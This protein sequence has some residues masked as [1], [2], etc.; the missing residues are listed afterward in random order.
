M[1]HDHSPQTDK[2]SPRAVS[3][4]RIFLVRKGESLPTNYRVVAENS[5]TL[6]CFH[7]RLVEAVKNIKI[8]V[9]N[10]GY[11]AL[12]DYTT[13]VNRNS[14]DDCVSGRPALI[15][16]VNYAGDVQKKVAACSTS[17]SHLTY[18]Y[19]KSRLSLLRKFV[20][21]GL[22]LAGLVCLFVYLTGG[23]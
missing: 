10:N 14:S 13:V 4:Q 12:L 3:G 18:S 6:V 21:G 7:G 15:V 5:E 22:L 23:W 20:Y 11:N 2:S 9:I 17:L 16:S 1:D 8:D 19:R